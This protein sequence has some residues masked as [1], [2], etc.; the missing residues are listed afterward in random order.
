VFELSVS[1]LIVFYSYGT[2]PCSGSPIE[3]TSVDL[4]I[5]FE[6]RQVAG[7]EETPIIGWEAIV[8][9]TAG[10]FHHSLTETADCITAVTLANTESG[11]CGDTFSLIAVPI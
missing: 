4:H 8:D 11:I 6:R 7:D 9:T 1:G 3:T 5:K 2:P 10:V